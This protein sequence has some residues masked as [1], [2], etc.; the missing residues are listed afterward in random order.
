LPDGSLTTRLDRLETTQGEMLVH[1]TRISDRLETLGGTVADVV[2][3]V[4]GVPPRDTR[5][6][7]QTTREAIHELKAIVNPAAMEAAFR[8]VLNE[9]HA[10]YWTRW[11]KAVTVTGV[12]VGAAAAVLRL[13]GVGG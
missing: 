8:K 4:G 5:G 6:S 10:A 3:E 12:L 7:R 9:K 2:A 13:A 11:Q 1:L